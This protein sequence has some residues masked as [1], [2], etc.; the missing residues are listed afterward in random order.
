MA[1]N[2]YFLSIHR[3]KSGNPGYFVV[4]NPTKMPALANFE[5]VKE[6]PVELKLLHKGD[7][8][9]TSS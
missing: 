4:L 2:F 6:L 9:E 1:I 7:K 3:H 8:F 5:G